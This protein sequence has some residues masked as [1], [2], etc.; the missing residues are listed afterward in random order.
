M[1]SVCTS[2]LCMLDIA[3]VPACLSF[4]MVYWFLCY[5]LNSI[6]YPQ[7]RKGD[8][9]FNPCGKY[10]VKLNLNGVPRKVGTFVCGYCNCSE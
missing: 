10:M 3:C 7:N 5:A 2:H 1:M 4:L 6:I 8:P 9:Q